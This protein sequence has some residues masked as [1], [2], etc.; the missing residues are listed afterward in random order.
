MSPYLVTVSLSPYL[1]AVR[2]LDH[3]DVLARGPEDI[4]HV[5]PELEVAGIGIILPPLRPDEIEHRPGPVLP[6]QHDR[7]AERFQ[8]EVRV[9]ER[10]RSRGAGGPVG[11]D[12]VDAVGVDDRR[13]AAAVIV[14]IE[15]P[16]GVEL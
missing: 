5:P 15:R 11:V 3:E 12:G 13:V 1:E 2:E 14:E 16:G 9:G 8:V 7:P 6:S 4:A 10:E